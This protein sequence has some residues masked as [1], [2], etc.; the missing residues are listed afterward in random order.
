MATPPPTRGPTPPL[1]SPDVPSLAAK[2]R[3]PPSL[4]DACLAR[5]CVHFFSEPVDKIFVADEW[6]RSPAD[7]TPK[8]T[9]Q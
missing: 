7:V 8:L 5:R 3:P 6:D 9:Y 4:T 1:L 2:R